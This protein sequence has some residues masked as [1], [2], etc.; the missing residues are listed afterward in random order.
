MIKTVSSK[1]AINCLRSGVL[2]HLDDEQ[3][4]RASGI[5]RYELL[6]PMGRID[7]SRHFR[8]L[9]LMMKHQPD[10]QLPEEPGL[11]HLFEDFLPLACVC[12]NAPTLREALR[13]YL[14]YRPLIGECDAMSMQAHPHG[15]LLRYQSESQHARLSAVSSM[16]NFLSIHALVRHYVVVQNINLGL[17]FEQ[18]LTPAELRRLKDIFACPIRQGTENSL[19]LDGRWLDAPYSGFNRSLQSYQLANAE[20]CLFNLHPVTNLVSEVRHLLLQRL[21]QS[22]DVALESESV[23]SWI[24]ARLNMTRWTLM[25]RLQQEGQPFSA[26]YNNIRREEA[27]RLLRD[28]QHSMLEISQ[29]LG[30]VNQSSFTRFFKEQFNCTPLHYRQQWRTTA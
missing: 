28:S 10:I 1:I 2:D 5:H 29:Q 14:L 19:L 15:L 6:N 30:F 26:L 7:A 16:Y 23:Q 21:W 3:L 27:C 9:Q 25:R 20:S 12:S 17:M 4:F 8:F 11:Q 18:R 24:C 13:L 22:D